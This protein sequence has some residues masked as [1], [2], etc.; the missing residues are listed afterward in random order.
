[1]KE[2]LAM[3]FRT[4]AIAACIAALGVS[5]L[6]GLADPRMDPS[7]REQAL[8]DL[9]DMI[10]PSPEAERDYAIALEIWQREN[11]APSEPR[12]EIPMK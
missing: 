3:S 9:R 11:A 5:G 1:M 10:A 12:P 4:T 7:D 2:N 6:P 8:R